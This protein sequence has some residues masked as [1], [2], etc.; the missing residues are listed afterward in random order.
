MQKSYMQPIHLFLVFEK[1]NTKIWISKKLNLNHSIM[2]IPN[3]WFYAINLFI[4]KELLMSTST[5]IE[6]SAIDCQNYNIDTDQNS[7]DQN[8]LEN[9]F[10]NNKILVFYNYYNYFLKSKYTFFL[11]INKLSK[12]LDSIDRIY[13]NANWL[14][15]ETSEMYG[16]NYKWKLDTRKLLL[17]Y[18]KIESPMLKEYQT[19]GTQ[20]VFYNIFENQVTAT[21]NETVEL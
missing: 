7:L 9:F 11:I 17:D 18:S 12:N 21:K 20:D 6:N 2:L 13:S 5:L 1:L 4:K 10:F 16:I 19:E 8:F 14:E 15:R 3:N